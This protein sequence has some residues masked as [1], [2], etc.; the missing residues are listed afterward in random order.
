MTVFVQL[1][2]AFLG[3]LGFA[4]L[5]GVLRRCLWVA[6]VGGMLTWGVYL[7][8][9]AWLHVE[10]LSCLAGRGFRGH[11]FGTAGQKTQTPGHHVHYARHHSSRA[12]RHAVLRHELCRARGSGAGPQLRAAHPA[13]R[14]GYCRRHQPCHRSARAACQAVKQF[15][16]ALACQPPKW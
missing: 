7:A 6:A 11:D 10:F 4:V 8:V 3:A 13:G 9:D 5:F 16:A 12:R 2:T 15:S 1:L 14:S